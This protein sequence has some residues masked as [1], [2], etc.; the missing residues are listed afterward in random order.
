MSLDIS[1]YYLPLNHTIVSCN[2][3]CMEYWGC[4]PCA[5]NLSALRQLRCNSP[6]ILSLCSTAHFTCNNVSS[7]ATISL[8][9]VSFPYETLYVPSRDMAS[10][11]AATTS[12]T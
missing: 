5:F 9:D 4:Q 6:T 2:P 12:F 3:C 10:I 11:F 8:T 1:E 7:C